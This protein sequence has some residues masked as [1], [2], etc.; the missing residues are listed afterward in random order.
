MQRNKLQNFDGS[1]ESRH[2]KMY[3][4][5]KMWLVGGVST[6]SFAAAMLGGFVNPA[7]ADEVSQDKAAGQDGGQVEDKKE[8]VLDAANT[9]NQITSEAKTE[10]ASQATSEA[11]TEVASQAA[12]EAKTE[13]ASQ[14]AS[15]A[16]TEVASQATSEAKTE[17]A[18][19]ATSEAKTEVASQ[20]T[21]EAKTEAASQA[22]SD[23]VYTP[24]NKVTPLADTG[25]TD[26]NEVDA[27]KLGNNDAADAGAVLPEGTNAQMSYN[28]KTKQ[29]EVIFVDAEGNTVNVTRRY[30]V[31]TK[32]VSEINRLLVDPNSQSTIYEVGGKWIAVDSGQND[33]IFSYTTDPTLGDYRMFPGYNFDIPYLEDAQVNTQFVDTEGNV[34]AQNQQDRLPQGQQLDK[35]PVEIPG[36]TW[37]EVQVKPGSGMETKQGDAGEVSITNPIK[38][39]G[40]D[41][42]KRA[43]QNNL[44]EYLLNGH[45]TKP[46]DSYVTMIQPYKWAPRN[47]VDATLVSAPLYAKVT[48]LADGS[49]IRIVFSTDAAGNNVVDTIDNLAA[50]QSADLNYEDDFWATYP[51][52][53]QIRS[54][55]NNVTTGSIDSEIV[56]VYEKNP[57]I[58]TPSRPIDTTTGEEIDTP[59]VDFPRFPG[60]PGDKVT[61]DPS[62]VPD[63]PG[64]DKPENPFEVTIPNEGGV[65][66]IPYTPIETPAEDIDTPSRP[67]DTT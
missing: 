36:Y 67:I 11:K 30:D 22:V 32:Q 39:L 57:V 16:K 50:G 53:A 46:G 60:K 33:I 20:A 9:S 5:G 42:G 31:L 27:H 1:N 25:F 64:Y 59:G 61:I 56:Y 63:I 7:S 62:E 13:V 18:S 14:A 29:T 51:T 4:S 23:A 54:F 49:S 52:G 65:I 34:I 28:P 15:E 3:K 17:V 10:V 19:Q 2:Y 55:Y 21:S 38:Q 47:Q 43:S 66:D 44:T 37:K 6:L 45:L 40:A 26:F 41:G 24:K 58:D 48:L 35:A 8:V 12:S